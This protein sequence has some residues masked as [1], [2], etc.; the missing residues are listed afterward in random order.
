MHENTLKALKAPFNLKSRP[1]T[2]GR[3]YKY[4][5][6]EDIVERMN[7]VFQGNWSTEV[8]ES[9]VIE[10]N[11]LVRVRVQAVAPNSTDSMPFFHEGYASQSIARFTGGANSGKAIDIGNSY[12]SAMSKAIKVACSR[13]GV[14]L[15]LEDSDDT[16][17]YKT[18]APVGGMSGETPQQKPATKTDIP[19]GPAVD[20]PFASSPTTAVKEEKP[21]P[22][23]ESAPMMDTPFTGGSVVPQSDQVTTKPIVNT[24]PPVDSIPVSGGGD[25][26][27]TDVQK[28]AIQI[29]M[30]FFELT[31]EQLTQVALGRADNLPT[32][33][34]EVTYSDAVKMIQHV[35]NLSNK[36]N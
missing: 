9:Q 23:K 27:L 21:A 20:L 36:E 32:S 31:F 24:A 16:G 17:S 13:W 19:S 14:A 4:V 35:N 10:D 34:D 12:K 25:E 28:R 5:P 3:N 29:K 33:I 30:D 2:G 11:I 22:K 18:G 26:L 1:G 15:N 8:L 6:S 7:T